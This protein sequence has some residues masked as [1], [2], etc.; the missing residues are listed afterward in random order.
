MKQLRLLVR[1]IFTLTLLLGSGYAIADIYKWVDDYGKTHFSDQPPADQGLN[2]IELKANTYTSVSFAP[3]EHD[4]GKK[5]VMYSASWCTYCKKARRYFKRENIPY[6]E[7]D[8]EKNKVAKK[9][10]R[11][12]GGK[13][14]PV[15]LVG[16]KRMNGFSI[17]GFERIYATL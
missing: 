17:D 11:S 4:V 14:V 6:V 9:Q 12:L 2:P 10:Y 1:L 15:I 7:Y 5:V 3:S 8:I 16:K 13:G